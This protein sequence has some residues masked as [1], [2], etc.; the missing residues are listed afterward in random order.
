MIAGHLGMKKMVSS[1]CKLKPCAER[2][3]LIRENGC[4]F[5]L[6]QDLPYFSVVSNTV[7]DPMHNLF[8]GTAKHAFVEWKN[9]EYISNHQF[10]DLQKMVDEIYVPRDTGRIPKKIRSGFSGFTADQWRLWTL[11]FSIICDR[12]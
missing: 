9:R 5:S 1:T 4:R 6:L 11:I 2:K 3:K 10:D 12:K 7:I 8:L